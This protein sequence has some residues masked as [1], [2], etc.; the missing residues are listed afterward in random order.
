M[1]SIAPPLREPLSNEQGLAQGTWVQFF[2][3]L[4]TLKGDIGL[5]RWHVGDEAYYMSLGPIYFFHIYRS[6]ID[7][8]TIPLPFNAQG[9]KIPFVSTS[10]ELHTTSGIQSVPVVDSVINVPYIGLPHTIKGFAFIAPEV[11]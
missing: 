9:R 6:E 7:A 3:A 4:G 8:T 2:N 11:S 5:R 10:L 1:R